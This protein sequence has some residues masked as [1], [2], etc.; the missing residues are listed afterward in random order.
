MAQLPN[1]G[2]PHSE[3]ITLESLPRSE[4]GRPRKKIVISYNLIYTP[5]GKMLVAALPKGICFLGCGNSKDMMLNDLQKRFPFAT[6][7]KDNLPLFKNVRLFFEKNWEHLEPIRVCVRGTDFQVRVWRELLEIPVGKVCSYGELAR[8]I[9][10]PKA[11]RAVG[12][13]VSRN[14][15]SYLV[16]CH[17]VICSNGKV[18]DFYWGVEKKLKFLNYESAAGK[19]QH[20]YANWEPTLF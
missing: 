3:V 18:G 19:R 17:R 12:N 20:G 10:R 16:P 2:K 1:F 15:V 7:K 9:G 6:L 11:P 13:A 5:L 14:P 4:W 8:K